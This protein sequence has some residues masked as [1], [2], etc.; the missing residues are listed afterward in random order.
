MAFAPDQMSPNATVQ[1]QAEHPHPTQHSP[2]SRERCQWRAGTRQGRVSYCTTS[3]FVA[4][5]GDDWARDCDLFGPGPAFPVSAAPVEGVQDG[6]AQSPSVEERMNQ[7]TKV[8]QEL[9]RFVTS[10]VATQSAQPL[11]G[12]AQDAPAASSSDALGAYKLDAPKFPC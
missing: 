8:V 6:V 11:E 10:G 12:A 7:L 3:K 2:A 9:A 5:E 4:Q 1:H